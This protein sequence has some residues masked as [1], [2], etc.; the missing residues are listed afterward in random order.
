MNHHLVD[1]VSGRTPIPAAPPSA[2]GRLVHAFGDECYVI[3]DVDALA[4][5]LTTVVSDAD[6]WLF[7]ASTGPLGAGRG[8]PATALFP[9]V[10]EDKIYDAVG[11]TGP[12]TAVIV[13]RGGPGALWH[14]L[15]PGGR[16]TYRITRRLY[17]SVLGDRL[18]YEEANHDL[19]VTFRATWQTSAR[20]GFVRTAV[21]VNDGDGAITVRVLDGLLNLLPGDVSEALQQSA[22]CLVDAFKQ[23]ERVPGTT[24]ALYT[25]A[26]QVI[27]RAEPMEALHATTVWSHG[28][29][30]PSVALTDDA[31]R[32]FD[33]GQAPPEVEAVRGRRGAYLVH[34]ELT[35]AVGAAHE[36]M[37]VADVARTQPEVAALVAALADP[38]ELAAAVRADVAAGAARL[39]QIVAATDGVQRTA[40]RLASAHHVAN[41]LFNDM[42]GGVFAFGP[43]VPG[44][45][46]AAFVG[47]ANRAV[48]RRHRALLEGLPALAPRAD[49]QAR[50]EAVGDPDL[51]RLTA[52]YLP[53]TFSRRHGDPSRPWNRFDIRVRDVHG[54]V[55]LDYQGNWRD[56][57]QNWEALGCTQP[58]FLEQLVVK[59]VNASTVD[60]HN[61]YRI[62]RAGVDWEVPEP[63]HPWSTIGYWGDHQVVYLTRL[64]ELALAHHPARLPTLLARDLF[65]YADVP[66]RIAGFDAMLADP[67]ATITFDAARHAAIMARVATLGS[68]A[69]LVHDAAGVYRVNLI[70]KLLVPA[71]AKLASFVPGGGVWMNTQRPEWNDANNALVGYGVSAVTACYLE[72]YLATLGELLAAQAG[73]TVPVSREVAAWMA[74]TRA[75]LAAHG[76]LVATPRTS[77]AARASLMRALGMAAT[78]YR[79]AVYAGGFSGREPV[80]VDD[81]RALAA[82]AGALVRHTLAQVRRPDGLVHAYLILDPRGPTDIGLE[83]LPEMLEGQVAAL[84]TRGL[85]DDAA[86]AILDALPTSRLYRA[87]QDSYLLYPDRALP[88]FLAKNRIP[89][90]TVARA[91][92]LAQLAAAPAAR[93]VVADPD[94]QLRFH[95]SL[96]NGAACA[97]RLEEL[98]VAE[99]L[100]AVADVDAALA[101]VLAA[102]EE[103]FAHRGFTGRSGTMFAY[104]GLG[105]IY[106]HMVGKLVLA[107]QERH[108]DAAEAGAGPE[109]LARLAAH[110]H[111]ARAGMSGTAKSPTTW[112]A[113]PLQPYSHSPAHGGARQPG[114]TGQVKEEIL[115]RQGELGVRVRN[116]RVSFAPRLLRRAEFLTQPDRF[117]PLGL[118]GET[119]EIAL[120]PGTLAFTY[121]QVPVVY[122]L[123]DERQIIVTTAAGD[124][125]VV[126]GDTLDAV[127]SASLFARTGALVRIDVDTAPGQP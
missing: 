72:R 16:L 29:P 87:D 57:F 58:D 92:V 49:H 12:S 32:G 127:R 2:T 114:M 54:A 115:I 34:A 83:P 106:W 47:Q 90:A 97:A 84:A 9:Y 53:L 3:D 43:M 68:D 24:L 19:A 70:E 105:S 50:L 39:A 119:R 8:S 7:A 22:S 33:H 94:G 1:L 15:D 26:A 113:F 5:F 124:R 59:F 66:Y 13:S 31:R 110:Y 28:L 111:A 108:R 6:H 74:A 65:V 81:V 125:H 11:V 36:W 123:R 46:F 118:D 80:A 25:L 18:V 102:Y 75:A 85:D 122:H 77:A 69:R 42:R 103:V 27:D 96:A 41:V 78:S 44:P 91:P 109:V 112:G 30:A 116:G 79:E 95:A 100:P 63:D 64:I 14:P 107:I 17:Q 93:V 117:T 126:P 121:C 71:L 23:T 38:A 35:I 89:A 48:W 73:Q 101:Q 56:I 82:A 10:T 61:P 55:V 86:L 120:P 67:R 60:G 40:D 21:L 52:E 4:P 51:T 98:R 45:D 88:T 99:A 104:E 37:I 62:G 20:Y 76:D